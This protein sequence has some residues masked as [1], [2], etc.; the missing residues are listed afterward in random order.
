[1]KS[2]ITLSINGNIKNYYRRT[3]KKKRNNYYARTMNTIPPR[4]F[5]PDK[6]QKEK[7]K[8]IE[9]EKSDKSDIFTVLSV[10]SLYFKFTGLVAISKKIIR[11]ERHVYISEKLNI[12]NFTLLICK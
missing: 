10:F 9:P 12:I 2:I 5:V 6:K 3:V 1:M 4:K 11:P 7:R 8:L